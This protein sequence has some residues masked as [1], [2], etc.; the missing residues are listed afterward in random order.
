MAEG[1]TAM[2]KT[3]KA[4]KIL[5]SS[6]LLCFI[7]IILTSCG[8]TTDI[9]T[10]GMLLVVY[11]GNGG[12]LGNKTATVRKLYAQSGSK[13]PDYPIDYSTNQYTVPSLGLAMR[14][15]YQLLGWYATADYKKD[16]EGEYL[17]LT[18]ADGNGI[19]ELS[20]EGT[21]VRKY[22]VK[23][24]GE[25]VYIS[26]EEA[27]APEEG[28]EK[29]T[30]TYIFLKNDPDAPAEER[31]ALANGAGY[32][33]CNGQETFTEIDDDVLRAAY[34]KAYAEKVY[35]ESEAKANSGYLIYDDLNNTLKALYEGIEHY[36]YTFGEATDADAGLDRYKIA[37]GYISIYTLF[38]ENEKGAFVEKDGQYVKAEEGEEGQRYAVNDTCVF[39][40]DT[41]EGMERYLGEMDY[42]DFAEDRVTEDVCVKEGEG[43]DALYVLTLHA[44]WEKKAAVNFHYNNGTGQVDVM[45]RY[46]LSDNITYTPIAPG[47]IIGKK[48]IVPTYLGH[49]FVGWSKSETEYDPWHFDTDLYPEGTTELNLYAYYVEGVYERIN[50]INNLS[51]IGANP[52]GKYIIAGDFDFGGKEISSSIFGLKEDTPFV[53]EILGYGSSITNFVYAVKGQNSQIGTGLKIGCALVPYA[54]DGAVISGFTVEGKV[55][56]NG[57]AKAIM[58]DVVH[59]PLYAAGIVGTAE[60]NVTIEDCDVTLTVASKSEK[61]LKSDAYVYDIAIGDVVAYGTAKV[62]NCTAKI[63]ST[64]LSGNIKVT[65]NKLK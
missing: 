4:M 49:T 51:K 50:N 16:P 40:L 30:V 13:I 32:Y 55:T 33:I 6:L 28:E 22:I 43:D 23:E 24:D 3:G 59:I 52:E 41:T 46:L 27:P 7:C 48:E 14:E 15:G 1:T 44:H 25:Y 65:E 64:G 17:K 42:W 18:Q 62:S 60:G 37:D 20:S 21:Y 19:Y 2:T 56:M 11:D 39:T 36:E 12:Y 34:E 54:G 26:M 29:K 63:D 58:D 31:L 10:S 5:V 47:K 8:K 53:G 45:T 38:L 9:D 61:A 35:S 57:I